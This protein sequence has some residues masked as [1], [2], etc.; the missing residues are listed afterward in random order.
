[1]NFNDNFDLKK[2]K[3]SLLS[4]NY[5]MDNMNSMDDMGTLDEM[6]LIVDDLKD[7][8]EAVISANSE[9]N[10]LELKRKIKLFSLLALA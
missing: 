6:A 2:A 9:L 1:M 8:I 3:A 7:A 4:E 5:G 10:G